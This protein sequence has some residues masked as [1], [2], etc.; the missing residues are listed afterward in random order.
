[1]QMVLGITRKIKRKM[2]Y[3]S[4]EFQGTSDLNIMWILFSYI[5]LIP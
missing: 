1:M 3:D 4:T 5:P 2:D